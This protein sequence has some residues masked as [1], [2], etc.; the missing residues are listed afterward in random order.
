MLPSHSSPPDYYTCNICG[1]IFSRQSQLKF[2]LKTH[3]ECGSSATESGTSNNKKRNY[4][5]RIKIHNKQVL[6]NNEDSF[7]TSSYRPEHSIN[8]HSL[9]SSE[10]D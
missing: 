7:L 3:L 2:H 1:K 6:K 8:R 5:K 9:L 10:S 4:K